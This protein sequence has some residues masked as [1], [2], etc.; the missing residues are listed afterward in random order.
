MSESKEEMIY[1]EENN[2]VTVSFHSVDQIDYYHDLAVAILQIMAG[3][4]YHNHRHLFRFG[5]PYD[6]PLDRA[7]IRIY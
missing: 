2:V 3:I 7:G 4:R 6:D 5:Q 1:E